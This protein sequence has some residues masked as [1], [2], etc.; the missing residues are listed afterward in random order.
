M[1]N[2]GFEVMFTLNLFFL[3]TITVSVMRTMLTRRIPISK[4]IT[5]K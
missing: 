1:F 2:V 4:D 3:I 5:R